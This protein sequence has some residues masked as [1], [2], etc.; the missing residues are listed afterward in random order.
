[1]QSVRAQG[2]RRW[3]SS[4]LILLN[5]RVPNVFAR[6][7]TQVESS[8]TARPVRHC[9]SDLRRREVRTRKSRMRNYAYAVVER[10]GDGFADGNLRSSAGIARHASPAARGGAG[11]S[12]GH[13]ARWDSVH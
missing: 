1:M 8:G 6:R 12:P 5:A 3:K 9:R 10:E 7:S 11:D 4:P 2:I 13:V